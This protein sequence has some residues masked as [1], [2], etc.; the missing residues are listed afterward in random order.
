[1]R[2]RNRNYYKTDNFET[3]IE[4]FYFSK[5]IKGSALKIKFLDSRD[6]ETIALREINIHYDRLQELETMEN[7]ARNNNPFK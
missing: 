3:F 2:I 6:G 1:M 4:T 7:I 5:P